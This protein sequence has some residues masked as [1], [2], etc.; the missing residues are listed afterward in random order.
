MFLW[1]VLEEKLHEIQH[2]HCFLNKRVILVLI[3]M[4]GDICTIVGINPGSGNDRTSEITAD[5]FHYS[6][7]IA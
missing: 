2:G 1:Y 3:V 5:I 6:I 4:E 7:R